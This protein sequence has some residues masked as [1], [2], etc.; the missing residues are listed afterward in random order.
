MERRKLTLDSGVVVD[1]RASTEPPDTMPTP[2]CDHRWGDYP[3][4]YWKT[5]SVCSGWD[6]IGYIQIWVC[7][8]CKGVIV[9]IE[10]R[11]GFNKTTTI[12]TRHD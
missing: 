2:G 5:R 4:I 11:D 9:N 6:E 10:N 3:N 7:D 1:V 8:K 12:P